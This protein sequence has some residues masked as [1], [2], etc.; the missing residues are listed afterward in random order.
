MNKFLLCDYCNKICEI[1]KIIPYGLDKTKLMCVTCNNK[2]MERI[3]KNL[4]E[5]TKSHYVR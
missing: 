3:L 1:T 4:I 2:E 5:N